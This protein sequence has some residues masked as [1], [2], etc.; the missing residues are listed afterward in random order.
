MEFTVDVDVRRIGRVQVF[1]TCIFPKNIFYMIEIISKKYQKWSFLSFHKFLYLEKYRKDMPPVIQRT[2][3][4]K[5]LYRLLMKNWLLKKSWGMK[6]LNS[7]SA[8]LSEAGFQ[9]DA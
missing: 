7:R 5:K 4:T 3:S 8:S 1:E 2:K 9:N 6:F